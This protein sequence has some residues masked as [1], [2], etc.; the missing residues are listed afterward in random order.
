MVRSH[1]F[2]HAILVVWTGAY[3]IWQS[4]GFTQTLRYQYPIFPTLVVL[5]S[6]GLWK[7]W[8]KVSSTAHENRRNFARLAIGTSMAIVLIS[9]AF[10]AF[11]FVNIYKEPHTQVDASRW[12]YRNV[13]GSINLVLDDN[14][15]KHYEPGSLSA[16]GRVS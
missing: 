8:D 16:N 5:G 2:Q 3:F 12:I 15:E 9:T 7:A 10:W 6:W 4:S 14:G 13:P 11:S 1:E